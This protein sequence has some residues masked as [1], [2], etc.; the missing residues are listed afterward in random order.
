VVYIWQMLW[1]VKLAVFYPHPENRQP[2]WEIILSVAILVGITTAAVF[3][4]KSRRYFI[5]GWLWYLGMLV[6]VIGLVQVGWQGRADR[7]T[8]L[9]QI[10]LYIMGT[11]TVADWWASWRGQREILSII[12]AVIIGVLSWWSGV[13][14]TFWRDSATLFTHA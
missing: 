3:L 7:Y 14:T 10:G 5:T 2:F 1:P 11:W 8:Y 6:P 12:A 9:P 4:R 13:Q